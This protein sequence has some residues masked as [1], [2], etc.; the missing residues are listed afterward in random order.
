LG[1]KCSSVGNLYF[2]SNSE[3]SVESG[4]ISE[5]HFLRKTGLDAKYIEL[6]ITE[7]AI[8][9]RGKEEESLQGL[10]NLGVHISIDDFGT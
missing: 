5:R 10:R 4:W 3:I 9:H 2:N 1:K 7:G 8:L 6:E